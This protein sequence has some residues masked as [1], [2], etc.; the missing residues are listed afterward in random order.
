[1]RSVTGRC[2]TRGACLTE[3]QSSLRLS[4]RVEASLQAVS[5]CVRAHPPGRSRSS[6]RPGQNLLVAREQRMITTKYAHK[7]IQCGLSFE[8]TYIQEVDDSPLI[9][10][11]LQSWCRAVWRQAV[12]ETN[13]RSMM[14]SVDEITFSSTGLALGTW[15]HRTQNLQ[16][17]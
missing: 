16:A 1:M 12:K 9:G 3:W 4:S 6:V 2:W 7:H 15:E 5:M 10:S 17:V 11:L 14:K 8:S 13:T